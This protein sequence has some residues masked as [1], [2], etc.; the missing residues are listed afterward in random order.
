MKV[1]CST[2][3][4]RFVVSVTVGVLMTIKTGRGAGTHRSAGYSD[5]GF[6]EPGTC[7][8]DLRGVGAR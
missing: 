7:A 2:G 6:R 4:G 8:V 5:G 1:S 3:R